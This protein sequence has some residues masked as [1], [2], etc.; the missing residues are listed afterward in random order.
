MQRT[1]A[2]G[3]M[4]TRVSRASACG[5]IQ[6]RECGAA[7]RGEQANVIRIASGKCRTRR[8]RSSI[9]TAVRPFTVRR[10]R[11]ATPGGS[12]ITFDFANQC[13]DTSFQGRSQ[14]SARIVAVVVHSISEEE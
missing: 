14:V 3:K 5:L 10:H 11:V 13:K 1:L 12:F 8:P 7:S 9:I 2:L 4:S 6:L